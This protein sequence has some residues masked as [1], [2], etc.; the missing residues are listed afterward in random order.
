[1]SEQASQIELDGQGLGRT[2]FTVTNNGKSDAAVVISVVPG[3]GA[4][5]S[6]FTVA[7][8]PGAIPSG[9]SVLVQV[10]VTVPPGTT[11]GRYSFAAQADSQR[12]GQ[13]SFRNGP[14]VPPWQIDFFV[15]A[16]HLVVP[17]G[18]TA[19]ANF[20]LTH[21]GSDEDAAV[22]EV[23]PGDGADPSWFS[24][25]TEP[26]SGRQ[27][28]D[29]QDFRGVWVSVPA[30]TPAGRHTFRVRLRPTD[31]GPGSAAVV[32]GPVDLVVQ[33]AAEWT[34]LAAEP[35]FRLTGSGAG[36]VDVV[37]TNLAAATQRAVL[38]I[39]PQERVD[40][41]WFAVEPAALDIAPGEPGG[42]FTVRLAVPAG[43]LGR[44]WYGFQAVA[45][46]AAPELHPGSATSRLVQFDCRYLAS[47]PAVCRL[48]IDDTW[49]ILPQGQNVAHFRVYNLALVD[50]QFY[51]EVVPM[52]GAE[53][54][55]FTI[56]RPQRPI[57]GSGVESFHVVVDAAAAESSGALSPRFLGKV[58][59]LDLWPPGPI[60]I[61]S[62]GS[63]I[64]AFYELSEAVLLTTRAT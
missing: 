64:P 4:V 59:P 45:R 3:A 17:A 8:P 63:P 48:E 11:V 13:M 32:F 40:R 25:A 18:G 19:T 27:L 50:G 55:W 44:G 9:V 22:F 41:S 30:G 7:Q 14:A 58:S 60:E 49:L 47:G 37:V 24:W 54:S 51:F 10:T 35:S 21:S 23:L 31:P 61:P 16:P 26:V 34:V 12:S 62:D 36:E 6:W 28:E 46:A 1:M 15:G 43:T 39:V 29:Q 33:T 53:A 5:A 42:R 57:R 2:L 52:D 56:D 38:D 20:V